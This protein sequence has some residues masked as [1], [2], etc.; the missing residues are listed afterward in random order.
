MARR[1]R[2][3]LFGAV[4]MF[5]CG[6]VISAYFPLAR[7]SLS[8]LGILRTDMDGHELVL[9]GKWAPGPPGGSVLAKLM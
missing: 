6:V 4:I 5:I 2:K 1:L 8:L 9:E 7:Y 3:I